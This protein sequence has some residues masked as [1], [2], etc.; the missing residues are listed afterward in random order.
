MSLEMEGQRAGATDTLRAYLRRYP[1]DAEAWFALADN[2]FH[3]RDELR[4]PYA[5]PIAEQLESFD[6]AL[7][8]D[9]SFTPA[10]IHPL[11]I[12]FRAAD[13]ARVRRYIESLRNVPASQAAA[14]GAYRRAAAVLAGAPDGE[15]VAD[16]LDHLLATMDTAWSGLIWQAFIA[17]A[18]PL[19]RAAALLPAS[20]RD[21][22]IDRM[23]RRIEASGDEYATPVLMQVLVAG[24]RLA[25]GRALLDAAA[26]R[27][28]RDV[29]HLARAAV[30]SGYAGKQYLGDDVASTSPL[31]LAAADLAAA[32]DAD[33]A[34]AIRRAGRALNDLAA[35]GDDP[36]AGALAR[37]AEGFARIAAADTAAGLREVEA[38]LD[39]MRFSTGSTAEAFA[40]RWLERLALYGATRERGLEL[41][42]RPWEGDPAYEVLR[43]HALGRA[44]AAAGRDADARAAYARFL[45]ALAGADAELGIAWRIE[46]ARAGAAP[47]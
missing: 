14:T 3:L 2:E 6:R 39:G 4:G 43:H 41:L 30:L 38:A 40:L 11:E 16:A 22:V 18:I 26:A 13:T 25:E 9:P 47:A 42:A 36:A 21:V 17:T 46:Q 45:A 24:G 32:I 31:V 23:R 7:A 20:G 12:V 19:A 27:S 5:R 8:L 34:A 15:R 29:S 44:L 1:D 37:A 33:D 28:K 10:L 35:T